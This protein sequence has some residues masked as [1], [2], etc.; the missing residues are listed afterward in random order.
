MPRRIAPGRLFWKF[1]AAFWLALLVASVM[2]VGF[3][4]L[5]GQRDAQAQSPLE[6]GPLGLRM[7][8]TAALLF[9]H[10]GRDVL[11]QWLMQAE[12]DG[13]SRVPPIYAVD[14]AGRDLLGRTVPAGALETARAATRAQ[15]DAAPGLA[16]REAQDAEGVLL[17]FVA[18]REL[19]VLPMPPRPPEMKFPPWLVPIANGL[20]ASVVLAALLAWYFARPIRALDAA[21]RKAGAGDLSVR[22]VPRLGNRRDEIAD[23]GREFDRMVRRLDELLQSQ[24]RLMHDVSHEMRSPLA[25]LQACVGLARRD[26]AHTAAM[27]DRIERETVQ[28]DAL[29]EEILTLARME[30]GVEADEPVIDAELSEILSEAL[31][32]ARIDGQARGV[33]LRFVRDGIARLRCRPRLL[34]RAIDNVLRNAIQHSTRGQ[35]VE[36]TL[37]RL[38]GGAHAIRFAD[39]G[40]GLGEEECTRVFEPFVRGAARGGEGFGLGLAIARRAIVAHGGSISAVPRAGGGLVVSITLP[41]STYRIDSLG[42]T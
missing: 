21:L 4:W 10:G 20:I 7:V 18:A 38:A 32:D 2:V 26:P 3:L 41:P 39:R 6:R 22:V 15:P 12:P 24:R 34:R 11:R 23:L 5:E 9:R 1:F 30:S 8:D 19:S 25:R 33:V 28:M 42:T 27:L 29:I 14:D 37:E 17:I 31:D 36:I 40:P 35:A 16:L 13:D